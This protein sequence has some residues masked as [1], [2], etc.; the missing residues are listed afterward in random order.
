MDSDLGIAT[1]G[2]HPG[3]GP[4]SGNVT[5]LNPAISTGNKTPLNRLPPRPNLSAARRTAAA[6]KKTVVENRIVPLA[7]EVIAFQAIKTF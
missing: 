4:F 5:G 6:K 7:K 1:N 3:P 2:L